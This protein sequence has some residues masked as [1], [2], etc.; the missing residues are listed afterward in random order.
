MKKTTHFWSLYLFMLLLKP[1]IP[2]TVQLGTLFAF[3]RSIASPAQE[4]HALCNSNQSAF[5][6]VALESFSMF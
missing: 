2:S 5:E 6:Q 3:M 1:D 4:K